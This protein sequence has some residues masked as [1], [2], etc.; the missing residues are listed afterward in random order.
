MTRDRA[1]S[2]PDSLA[3]LEVFC[4]QTRIGIIPTRKADPNIFRIALKRITLTLNMLNFSILC[5][6]F[7]FSMFYCSYEGKIFKHLQSNQV[8]RTPQDCI[9]ELIIWNLNPQV[10]SRMQ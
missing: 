10:V 5:D 1:F 7:P 8:K 4:E 6:L 3:S 9:N 2:L